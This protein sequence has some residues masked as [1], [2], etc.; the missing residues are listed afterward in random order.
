MYRTLIRRLLC[1]MIKDNEHTCIWHNINNG[2]MAYIV[3]Y[4]VKMHHFGRVRV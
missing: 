1:D 2:V 4:A 3:K